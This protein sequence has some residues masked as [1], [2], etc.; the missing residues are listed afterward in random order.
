VDLKTKESN[1]QEEKRERKIGKSVGMRASGRAIRQAGG[2][3]RKKE[4]KS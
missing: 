3:N 4:R 2:P 1:K